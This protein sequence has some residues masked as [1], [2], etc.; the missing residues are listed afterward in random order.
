MI[1]K[2]IYS[3]RSYIIIFFVLSFAGWIYELIIDLV[4]KG[5]FINQGFFLGP[6]LPIYGAGG[7]CIIIFLQKLYKKPILTFLFSMVIC[8]IIEYSTSY[9]LEEIYHKLWWNYKNFYLNLNGRICA[10]GIIIFGI[11]AMLVNYFFSPYLNKFISKIPVKIQYILCILLI[12]L[13]II[14]FSFS[15]FSPHSAL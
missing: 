5:T 12:I 10:E 3:I 8:S 6:Y 4:K 9:I 14:D 15:I 2:P 11:F 7:L 1:K 13:F